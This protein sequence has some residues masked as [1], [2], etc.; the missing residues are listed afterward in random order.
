MLPLPMDC[1]IGNN[2]IFCSI[3]RGNRILYTHGGDGELEALSAAALECAPPFHSRYSH[4]AGDRTF[5][6]LID[7][8]GHTYFVI[9][10]SLAGS[11]AAHRILDLMRDSFHRASKNGVHDEVIPVV[12]RLIASLETL[13]RGGGGDEKT[14]RD[15]AELWIDMPV[16]PAGSLPLQS[17]LTPRSWMQQ[18][19]RRLWW[20]HV[21]IVI[22]VDV[23]LCLVLLGIWLAVCR[24]F[25]CID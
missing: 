24:G 11:A 8:D 16:R 1:S 17:S 6:Y 14:K 5:A 2:I 3:S 21:K 23:F 18:N 25:Q 10:N 9:T 12:R 15:A 20:R 4:T 22:A 19:C 13:S 7:D